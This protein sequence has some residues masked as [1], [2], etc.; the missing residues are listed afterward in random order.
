MNTGDSGEDAGATILM[1]LGPTLSGWRCACG[2][3]NLP[4]EAVC[5]R[6][7]AARPA[8]EPTLL[9]HV[10]APEPASGIDSWDRRTIIAVGAGIGAL[11]ASVGLAV[12]TI[13]QQ[14][15]ERR[16]ERA[17]DRARARESSQ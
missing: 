4:A 2:G 8:D 17:R 15:A 14:S 12:W 10:P 5:F 13:A 6:C 16:A 7:G 1:P 11:L 3:Q 9:A